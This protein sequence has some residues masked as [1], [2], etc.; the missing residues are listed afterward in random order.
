MKKTHWMS[1]ALTIAVMV[2]ILTTFSSSTSTA[3]AAKDSSTA[4]QKAELLNTLGIFT[5]SPY[6][7]ELDRASTRL[8]GAVM[9]VRLLGKE[10]EAQNKKYTHPFQDVP[11]WASPYVGY[12]YHHD[13][14]SGMSATT[15]GSGKMNAL[16]YVTFILR[17][18]GY[19]DSRGDFL[20]TEA[21]EKA[22]E[23]GLLSASTSS[24]L[25]NSPFLRA[26]IAT[27]TYEALTTHL[28]KDNKT[29]LEHLVEL[30]AFT[31]EQVTQ[32]NHEAFIQ[33]LGIE[34]TDVTFYF[35]SSQAKNVYLSGSFNGWSETETPMKKNG[36]E[37]TV[38]V[39][40][41]HTTTYKFIADGSYHYDPFNPNMNGINYDAIIEPDAKTNK[42]HSDM[43][44]FSSKHFDYFTVEDMDYT[45]HLEIFYR[46]ATGLID[47]LPVTAGKIRIYAAEYTHDEEGSIYQEGGY[48][49]YIENTKELFNQNNN[50]DTAF[51]IRILFPLDHHAFEI[52]M[53]YAYELKGNLA[54]KH[55]NRNLSARDFLQVSNGTSGLMDMLAQ[56]DHSK[57]NFYLLTS[58][59]YYHVNILEEK[60]K[61]GTFLLSLSEKD[62]L[63]TIQNKYAK[64]FG[65]DLAKTI[66]EWESWLPTINEHQSSIYMDWESYR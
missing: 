65:E 20:Y 21:F 51:L 43:K 16:Q 29:L 28:K 31:Q 32:T 66:R 48:S 63:E 38:T 24:Q 50:L 6:G 42:L 60:D 11:V 64:A 15:F 3:H 37:F 26:S 57:I 59:I 13:L 5:G 23:I 58:F 4:A 53:G 33:L 61:F 44:Y 27:L 49:L 12:L 41:A 46:G 18:L 35:Y 56:S 22:E 10:T 1:L 30:G 55:Y 9:L 52:A 17:V 8:E 2:T 39:P 14:T 54:D 19:D 7:F 40:L 62:S 47:Y 34:F 45:E 25:A 36:N